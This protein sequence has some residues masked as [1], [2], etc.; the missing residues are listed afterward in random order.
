MSD[1]ERALV[2][3]VAQA[4]MEHAADCEQC[5]HLMDRLAEHGIEL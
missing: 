4:L 3:Q 5:Q 2:V 1:D